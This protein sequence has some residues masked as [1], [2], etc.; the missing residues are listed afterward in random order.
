MRTFSCAAFKV[1]KLYF[2]PEGLGQ[3][4]AL[5]LRATPANSALKSRSLAITGT[6]L[7][8]ISRTRTN[9][10]VLAQPAHQTRISQVHPLVC[11]YRKL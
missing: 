8:D 5:L 10:D 2:T 9:S 6:A 4:G 1:L 3:I 11:N 7:A